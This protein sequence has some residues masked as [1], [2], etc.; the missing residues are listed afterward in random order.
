MNSFLFNLAI[1]VLGSTAI[2]HLCAGCFPQY[3]RNTDIQV[4]LINQVNYLKFFNIFFKNK[5]FI[6]IILVK[7]IITQI[8]SALISIFIIIRGVRKPDLLKLI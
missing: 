4:I 2:C 1:S 3:L 8:W 7:C 6:Y 5:V